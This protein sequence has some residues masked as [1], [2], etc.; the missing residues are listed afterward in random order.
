MARWRFL[1]YLGDHVL[2]R[3]I[4]EDAHCSLALDA[5]VAPVSG[6]VAVQLEPFSWSVLSDDTT[7]CA[8]QLLVQSGYGYKRL[9]IIF[10]PF[11]TNSVSPVLSIIRW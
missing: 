10:L 6:I 5:F 8:I 2:P 3:D 7:L 9:V 1:H 4:L 11:Q